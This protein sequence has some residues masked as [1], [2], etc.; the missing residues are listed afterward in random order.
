M[1]HGNRLDA[2]KLVHIRCCCECGHGVFI[3][4]RDQDMDSTPIMFRILWPSKTYVPNT[5]AAST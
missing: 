5:G 2:S 3:V 4:V 1:L